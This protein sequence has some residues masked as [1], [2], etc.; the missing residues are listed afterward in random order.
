MEPL[1]PE[2]R[3]GREGAKGRLQGGAREP[4]SQPRKG[5]SLTE[6]LRAVPGS[7]FLGSLVG[8]WASL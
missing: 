3:Q 7:L 2:T 6:E 1:S 5:V 8:E 4:V